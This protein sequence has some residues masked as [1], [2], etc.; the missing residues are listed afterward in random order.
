MT[1]FISETFFDTAIAGKAV[2][3]IIALGYPR[4]RINVIVSDDQRRRFLTSGPLPSER[5]GA[6][7]TLRE[8]VA[9]ATATGDVTAPLFVAGPVSAALAGGGIT[10]DG[11]LG[12]L[13]RLGMLQRDTLRLERDV[14]AGG[15]VIGVSARDDD[16]APV[17]LIMRS[18][19]AGNALNTLATR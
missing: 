14:D 6:T 18:S 17:R 7:G 11:L 12:A 2:D 3:D 5:P 13:S 1:Q 16:R 15:F 4:G 10:T 19:E 8:I 9:S